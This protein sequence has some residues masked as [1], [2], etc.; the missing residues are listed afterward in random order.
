MPH[1]RPA[2]A[3]QSFLDLTVGLRRALML[4]QVFCPGVYDEGF[5]VV[6]FSFQVAKD[7]PTR[8]NYKARRF[9]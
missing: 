9:W 8:R 1:P 4:T 2:A 6:I 5:Q 7:A 3:L